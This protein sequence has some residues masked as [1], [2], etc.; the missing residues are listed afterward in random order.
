MSEKQ[1]SSLE[2]IFLV[3]VNVVKVPLDT[4]LIE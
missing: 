1:L 4:M 3:A 2:E